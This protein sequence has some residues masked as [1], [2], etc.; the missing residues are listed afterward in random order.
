MKKNRKP[1]VHPDEASLFRASM[2][3]VTPLPHP[4]R[5]EHKRPLP[6]PIPAQRL[7][8]DRETL[9]DSLSDHLPWDAGME[10]GE[11]L[12][13]ARN[14]IGAPTLRKLRRG[15]WVIQDE[16]DLH[17]LTT[18]EARGLLV[19]FLNYCAR[20]GLRC[21]RIIHG[22]GLR[23]KNREPVLKRKVAVWLMQREEILAFCQAP[24][25]D[26]GSGAVVVLL[27]GVR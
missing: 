24:R 19:E 23:S 9:K 16:L 6:R 26:G 7:R 21:V 25:A 5:V 14:G 10:T 27:K 4:K 17:G 15:H 8:D 2:S 12:S 22:K 18:A 20:R 1:A 13:F 11:E 3:D